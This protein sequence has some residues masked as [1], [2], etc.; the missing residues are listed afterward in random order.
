MPT[1]PSGQAHPLKAACDRPC[2]AAA[3]QAAV[4]FAQDQRGEH[5][6]AP[7]PPTKMGDTHSRHA[8]HGRSLSARGGTAATAAVTRRSRAAAAASAASGCLTRV[9]TRRTCAGEEHACKPPVGRF[10]IWSHSDGHKCWPYSPAGLMALAPRKPEAAHTG[11]D[12]H[13]NADTLQHRCHTCSTHVVI[14]QRTSAMTSS[15][16]IR[17]SNGEKGAFGQTKQ[18][19]NAHSHLRWRPHST[20]AVVQHSVS[21][22]KNARTHIC[23]DVLQA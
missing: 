4:K 12:L 10:N 3:Y 1:H 11:I 2:A 5:A 9:P 13:L 22:N 7:H 6:A 19:T 18:A 8:T 14:Q 15:R 23:D 20:P 17:F 16:H 21:A